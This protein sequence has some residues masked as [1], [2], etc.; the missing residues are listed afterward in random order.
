MAYLVVIQAGA[1]MAYST[2]LNRGLQTS[3]DGEIKI[4]DDEAS[5][6]GKNM[7]KSLFN[8]A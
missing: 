8:F 7:R 6:I 1:N 5:W 2:V 4:S 3:K